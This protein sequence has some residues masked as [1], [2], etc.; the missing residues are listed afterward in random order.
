[1][2]PPPIPSSDETTPAKVAPTTPRPR[3]RTRYPSPDR[4]SSVVGMVAGGPGSG[5]TGPGSVVPSSADMPGRG[6]AIVKAT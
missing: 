2:I 3:W 4:R 5:S 1:M 6:R